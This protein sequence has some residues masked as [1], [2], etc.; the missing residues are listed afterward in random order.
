MSGQRWLAANAG[1]SAEPAVVGRPRGRPHGADNRE[2][3]FIIFNTR[4]RQALRLRAV[5]GSHSAV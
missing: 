2:F 1:G 4:A 3:R 5:G